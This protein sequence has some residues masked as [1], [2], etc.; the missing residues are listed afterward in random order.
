M[1]IARLRGS[2]V[3]LVTP[4]RDNQ[5]AETAFRETNPGPVK[6]ALGLMGL[7]APRFACRSSRCTRST[8]RNCARC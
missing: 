5:F 3:P 4:F 6:T 8:R 2:Q 7:I 1:D